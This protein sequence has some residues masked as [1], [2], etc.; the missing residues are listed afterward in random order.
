M[1][2]H[3]GFAVHQESA[4]WPAA[5]RLACVPGRFEKHRPPRQ[6]E[7]HGGAPAGAAPPT[8]KACS[9]ALASW[10]ICFLSL[11]LKLGAPCKKVARCVWLG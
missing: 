1:C 4:V 6:R 7:R 8:L 11:N 3:L 9:P 2:S 10:S 5:A